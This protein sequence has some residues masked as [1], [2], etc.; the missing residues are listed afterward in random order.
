MSCSVL[1]LPGDAAIGVC[2]YASV[3]SVMTPTSSQP[4]SSPHVWNLQSLTSLVT[5]DK[6]FHCTIRVCSR[7]R[8]SDSHLSKES[9]AHFSFY[10]D[11][12]SN[13]NK[14]RWSCSLCML[15]GEKK[16]RPKERKVLNEEAQRPS[17]LLPKN[18]ACYCPAWSTHRAWICIASVT[19]CP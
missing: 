15:K 12:A 9:V 18:W 3:Q 11:A 17:S 7:L 19:D 5:A 6:P 4:R 14:D 10:G 1:D 8:D 16:N 13:R 2:F